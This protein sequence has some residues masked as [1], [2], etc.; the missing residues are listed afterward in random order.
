MAFL[1]II[2]LVFAL[3]TAL[4]FFASFLFKSDKD[5]SKGRHDTSREFVRFIAG[6]LLVVTG[7]TTVISSLTVVPTRE[8]GVVLSFGK[9]AGTLD[10]GIHWKLP[11]QYVVDMDGT[12]QTQFN[13]GDARTEIRLGNQATAYV[14]NTLRWSINTNGADELY[15]DYRKFETI[16]SSLVTPELAAALNAAF[17]DYDPLAAADTTGQSYDQVAEDVKERLQDRVGDR[18]IIQSLIIPKVD[19]DEGTQS[20]IDALQKEIGNTR[21]AEQSKK[22]AEQTKLKNDILAKTV[23]PEIN[24]ATCL[25][26]AKENGSDLPPAFNCFGGGNVLVGPKK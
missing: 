19:F 13:T 3:A 16:Q 17:A 10:N 5:E 25:E 26:I 2:A 6:V 9:P 24:Q 4:T 20:R 1:F 14:Q 11:W 22:T 21:I 8:V 18:I 7:I 15:M 23:T 12:T